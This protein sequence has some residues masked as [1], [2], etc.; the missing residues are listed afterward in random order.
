VVG[1]SD[2]VVTASGKLAVSLSAA[3]ADMNWAVHVS[4]DV[5]VADV[6]L[7]VGIS[8]DDTAFFFSLSA[9][10]KMLV[11]PDVTNEDMEVGPGAE[12]HGDGDG[13]GA[14]DGTGDGDGDGDGAGDGTGDGDGDPRCPTSSPTLCPCMP[15]ESFTAVSLISP[16]DM[17]GIPYDMIRRAHTLARSFVEFSIAL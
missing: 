1:M 16:C 2:I 14:G 4:G 7:L 5:D 10:V 8:V 9:A 17:A 15:A 13:D 11:G 6:A 12:G 3:A